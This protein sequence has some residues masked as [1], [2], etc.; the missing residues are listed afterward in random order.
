L[1]KEIVV[2]VPKGVLDSLEEKHNYVIF[3]KMDRTG[4]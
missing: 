4:G 2:Y 1:D 3:E